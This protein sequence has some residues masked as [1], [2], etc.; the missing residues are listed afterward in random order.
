M[1]FPSGD[2]LFPRP[3]PATHGSDRHQDVTRTLFLAPQSWDAG[4]H[5]L[6]AFATVNLADAAVR[7]V[8][9]SFKLPS[10]FVSLTSLKVLVRADSPGDIYW[11]ALVYAAAEGETYGN[12]SGSIAYT[13]T[14][15][16]TTLALIDITSAF[17]SE[18]DKNDFIGVRFR[19]DATNAL[20]TVDDTVRVIGLLLTYI[21]EQ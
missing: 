17:P 5:S 20:D 7:A 3:V 12:H 10:D 15:V 2:N 11:D 14:A 8:Y 6:G 13:T 4:P 9:W 18:A 21:A 1:S 19:R 16:G